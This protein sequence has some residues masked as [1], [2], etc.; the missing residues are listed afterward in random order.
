MFNSPTSTKTLTEALYLGF[1]REVV[2]MR[3]FAA[4]NFKNISK[5]YVE[6][7]TPVC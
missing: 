5:R 3:V 2:F 7:T 4:C 1:P 6:K